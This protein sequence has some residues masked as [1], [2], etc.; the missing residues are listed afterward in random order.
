MRQTLRQPP[1][2]SDDED[3]IRKKKHQ[4]AGNKHSHREGARRRWRD[5]I[6]L[7]ERRRYEAVWA[8]NRGALLAPSSQPPE[9]AALP[10]DAGDCVANVVVREIWRRSR[11]PAEELAEV[12]DLV[13]RG[14]RGCWAR[15]SSWWAC[16]SST[17]G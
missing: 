17:R 16:G 4:R 2:K 9:A 13:D 3:E 7:R 14:R 5:E 12:W 8:S 1:S 6:T 11:L 15:P 10:P